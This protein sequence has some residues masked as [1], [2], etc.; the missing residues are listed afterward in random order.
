MKLS[1]A[2]NEFERAL[3][4]L[5]VIESFFSGYKMKSRRTIANSFPCLVGQTISA[6]NWNKLLSNSQPSPLD[7]S[8]F[9]LQWVFC[10]H[11]GLCHKIVRIPPNVFPQ[12]YP[13]LLQSKGHL[14]QLLRKK[15][16]MIERSCL[17]NVWIGGRH[18]TRLPIARVYLDQWTSSVASTLVK[19]A[20]APRTVWVRITLAFKLAQRHFR[21]S[22]PCICSYYNALSSFKHFNKCNDKPN[23]KATKLVAGGYK[24]LQGYSTWECPVSFQERLQ[25]L[26]YYY[27]KN[28]FWW[29]LYAL[30][31]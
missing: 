14:R 4:I 6:E 8:G 15:T 5:R 31:V 28:I 19:G 18:H 16:V 3:I 9:H 29:E 30:N 13:Q 26:E 7:D 2:L 23:S 11:G 20:R 24:I 25:A 12:I 1:C 27:T 22:L 17:R 21:F 10:C